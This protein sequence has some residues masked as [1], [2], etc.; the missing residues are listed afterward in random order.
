MLGS[1]VFAL[2]WTIALSTA[3]GGHFLGLTWLVTMAVLLWL[4]V[5]MIA[6]PSAGLVL[7]LLWPV[8]RRGSAAANGICMLAGAVMGMILAP[9]ASPQMLGTTA[10][11]LTVFAAV[12]AVV[13]ASYVVI[14]NRLSR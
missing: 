11:Q 3:P 5:F 9:L 1:T 2:I 12:G 7:S 10:I 8:T 13:A 4:S 14:A 6:L